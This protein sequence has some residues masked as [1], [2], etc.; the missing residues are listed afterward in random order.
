MSI[1]QNIRLEIILWLSCV[2][3]IYSAGVFHNLEFIVRNITVGTFHHGEKISNSG[4]KTLMGTSQCF[5]V[6]YP[7]NHFVS[8]SSWII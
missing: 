8:G 4:L 7:K 1:D 2:L 5:F 3:K 6:Y